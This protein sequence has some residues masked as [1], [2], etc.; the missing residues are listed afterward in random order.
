MPERASISVIIPCWQD[1]RPLARL[2][3]SLVALLQ[4]AGIEGEIIVV[5]GASSEQCR[6]LCARHGAFW[7]PTAPCRGKQ[8]RLGAS[9][10]RHPLLWFLHADAYLHGNPLPP[11]LAAVTGDAVGGY[12]KFRFAGR[13]GWQG[14]L[15]ER[16]VALRTHFG[17]PYGDQGLFVTAEV[18][19]CCGQHNPW[20]LFEEVELVRR[21]RKQGRFV[22]LD[23]GVRVD[24]RRWQRDG[25]WRRSLRNRLLALQF[26]CGVPVER[27]AE[28]YTARPS[29]RSDG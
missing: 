29:E 19:R 2:L 12:F 23:D 4:R 15:L 18:Y 27:L 6:L 13:T 17:V 24:P 11:I 5:D 10:A 9:H 14:T 21:L 1:E 28:R 8:L 26:A 25:W 20:P 7:L 22:R 3:E 16:L